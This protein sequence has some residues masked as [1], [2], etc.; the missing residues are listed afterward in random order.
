MYTGLYNRNRKGRKNSFVDPGELLEDGIL[1][2]GL[3]ERLGGD[4]LLM[5]FVAEL[6]NWNR[7]YNLTSVRKPADIVT[8]HILDSLSI[9]EHLRG[10][11]IL[12]VGTGAG[13]PGIPLAI[14]CPEREFVLLD[15]SSKKL[16]FVQQTLGILKLDNV[17]LENAR[18]DEYQPENLFDTIVCRAFSDLPDFYRNTSRLCNSGGCILAMKGVYPMTEVESLDDKSVISDVVALKV[19]GLD[20]ERHLVKMHPT[21]NDSDTGSPA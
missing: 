2:L 5:E 1:E 15:S 18:V 6:M 10:D 3:E 20:A 19:P 8:R 7:V 4:E 14:A 13:L 9:L 16:R 12:D 21:V 17:T 11:R